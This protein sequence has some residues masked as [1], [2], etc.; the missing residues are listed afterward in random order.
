MVIGYDNIAKIQAIL[1][2][3]VCEALQELSDYDPQLFINESVVQGDVED[4]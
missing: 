4:A 3:H 1:N 2:K